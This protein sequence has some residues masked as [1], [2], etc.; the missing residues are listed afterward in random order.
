[1]VEQGLIQQFGRNMKTTVNMQDG[2][3]AI[4]PIL[5]ISYVTFDDLKYLFILIVFLICFCIVIFIGEIIYANSKNIGVYALE[6]FN[7]FKLWM[8]K[9]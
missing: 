1:M 4:K 3:T 5:V 2:Q 7:N 9:W 6:N 8:Q